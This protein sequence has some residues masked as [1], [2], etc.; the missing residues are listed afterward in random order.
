MGVM[1]Q[2]GEDDPDKVG[3][4]NEYLFVLFTS[5][6]HPSPPDGTVVFAGKHPAFERASECL[7][8]VTEGKQ[9]AK[10]LAAERGKEAVNLCVEE[11]AWLEDGEDGGEGEDEEGSVTKKMR[12]AKK[13]KKMKKMEKINQGGGGQ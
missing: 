3:Q 6:S 5:Y 4:E 1:C 2:I 10:M 13:M 11:V 7:M 9:T 8:A 12:K